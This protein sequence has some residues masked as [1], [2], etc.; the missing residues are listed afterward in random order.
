[1]YHPLLPSPAH[2]ASIPLLSAHS[3]FYRLFICTWET[4][5]VDTVAM[6]QALVSPAANE[7]SRCCKVKLQKNTGVPVSQTRNVLWSHNSLIRELARSRRRIV[8]GPSVLFS[9]IQNAPQTHCI[10]GLV[11]HIGRGKAPWEAG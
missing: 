5:T 4:V 11:D 10:A 8:V 9:P 3:L 1:M 7:Y 6:Q 2:T